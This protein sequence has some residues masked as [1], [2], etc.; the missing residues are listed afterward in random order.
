MLSLSLSLSLSLHHHPAL[1]VQCID[2]M[3][4]KLFSP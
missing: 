4:L 3:E 2:P 1:Q